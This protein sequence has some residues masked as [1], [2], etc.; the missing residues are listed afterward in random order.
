M[1]IYG[2][3]SSFVHD[4]SCSKLSSQDMN[5]Q[6]VAM[7]ASLSAWYGSLPNWIKVGL[8]DS[9][10]NIDLAQNQQPPHWVV[11]Y[12]S[13]M[14]HTCIIRLQKSR[15]PTTS[16]DQ[17]IRSMVAQSHCQQSAFA[18]TK[19][20][21]T[22]LKDN[23][24]FHYVNPMVAMTLF[25]AASIWIRFSDFTTDNTKRAQYKKNLIILMRGIE[26]IASYFM[27]A[28]AYMNALL[29]M[30]RRLLSVREFFS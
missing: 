17:S 10:S 30:G 20:T 15:L 13:M 25:E 2:R 26:N 8:D 6:F 22:F 12:L 1:K 5:R 4:I 16:T 27:V 11:A 24:F 21:C 3:I 19:F 18:I 29:E 28:V 7:E 14:Y 23:P 9:F